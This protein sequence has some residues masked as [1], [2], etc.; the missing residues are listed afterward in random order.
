MATDEKTLYSYVIS[1]VTSVFL[2]FAAWQLPHFT[3]ETS[4]YLLFLFAI[5]LNAWMGGLKTGLIVTISGTISAIVFF[6]AS[7]MDDS[8]KLLFSTLNI[9][10][11]TLLG[12]LISFVIEKYKH[13]DEVTEYRKKNNHYKNQLATIEVEVG[14]MKEEIRMRDEFLS[15]ASHELKTPLTTMLLKIQ[16]LLHNIRNVSLANF[17]VENLMNQLE[18]AED[19]TKRLSRMISDLLN[20]SLITTGKL[21]LELSKENIT[22]IVEEVSNEFTEKMAKDGYEFQLIA[23]ESIEMSV[24][25]IRISQV[26][27]NLISNSMRY[28]NGKP[29]EVT[30]K[31][32]NNVAYIIVKDHGLGIEK[33]AQE[34]IFKLFER[35]NPKNGIKGLGVGLFICNQ[36]VKAHGGTI[37][38]NSEVDNGSVFTVALPIR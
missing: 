9:T 8:S 3:G 11:F 6:L 14:K 28:G 13:T 2:V 19:Q 34:K 29:I 25:K 15:I 24:D 4:L 1:G 7:G 35:G 26:L 10:L 22:A 12:V 30:V 31:R 36:I 5:T 27:T 16:M 21:N 20:V 32:K 17:S 23:P 18:T 37:T 33:E 38:V